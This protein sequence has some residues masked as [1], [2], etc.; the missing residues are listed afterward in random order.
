MKTFFESRNRTT[1]TSVLGGLALASGALQGAPFLYA[2][3]DLIL[4]FRQSGNA[5]DFAVNLG[6][7]TNYNAVP[8]GTSIPVPALTSS[9]FA[10]AFPSINGVSWSVS[11]A[12]RPPSDPAFPLQ[13]LWVSAPRESAD[14]PSLAWLRKGAF[15]QGTAGGQIAGIGANAVNASSTQPAGP[16]NTEIGVVIPVTSDFAL[17]PLL[18]GDGNYAG[19]FQGLVEAVTPDDFDSDPS[20]VSRLDL[21]ELL[22]GTS[23]EGTLNTPGR[24]LGYFELKPD[25]TLTF[26]NIPAAPPVPAISS[27][28]R[29][30]D[31]TTVSFGTVAGAQYTLR[32]V[33]GAGLS[34]PPSTW[35]VGASLTGDGSVQSLQD[36]SA[37]LIRFYVVEVTP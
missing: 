35:P 2:P 23:A 14:V 3:S 19:T 11:A 12:N 24:F 10:L 31:V 27:I 25:G 34:T 28:T 8:L 4:T 22:P 5:S 26:A 21:Y 13:T 29:A 16:D 1:L 6:K 33:D 37:S 32:A 9:Q 17:S 18:G 15:V 7:A 30:G 36:T 20:R